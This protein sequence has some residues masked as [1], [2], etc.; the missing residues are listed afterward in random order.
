MTIEFYRERAGGASWGAHRARNPFSLPTPT[1]PT[2]LLTIGVLR[3]DWQQMGRQYG[4]RAASD[5]AQ[6]WDLDWEERVLN[7]TGV[8]AQSR[9]PSDRQAYRQQ[10]LQ[11]SWREVDALS[12]ELAQFMRGVAEGAAGALAASA[13]AEVVPDHLKIL[14]LNESD[15]ALHP[16]W[17]FAADRPGDGVRDLPGADSYV[18]DHDNQGDGCNGVWISGEGTANGHALAQRAVQ[19]GTGRSVTT[20]S[21]VAVPDDPR[22][23]VFWG[24]GRAGCLGGLGALLNDAGVC[25]LTSG[26]Q[27]GDV[28]ETLAPGVKDFLLAAYGVIFSGS[29]REAAERITVGTP[30]YRART[31]RRTVLR[32]RGANVMFGDPENACVVESNARHFCI[33]DAADAG[34][35][36]HVAVMANHFVADSSVDEHGRP[37]AARP[38]R[39]FEPGR[40]GSRGRFWTGSWWLQRNYG[41]ASVKSVKQ[42]AGSHTCCDEDGTERP[43]DQA[44][45]RQTHHPETWCAHRAGED[46]RNE[47]LGVDG[48]NMTTVFDLTSREVWFVPGWPCHYAEWGMEWNYLNLADYTRAD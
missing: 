45:G 35:G 22:A 5:I 32:F 10:Y 38:M 17:D 12:P 2:R 16:A 47:P 11:R 42:F 9:T 25:A 46:D 26:S 44:T 3:G 40:A 18:D 13:F 39:E 21:Y 41:S 29:A 7:C 34:D 33:R 24:F 6:H 36:R 30:E 1:L 37:D 14:F 20:V 27:G 28:D 43:P 23:H 48:N 15:A 8:W 31:G 19:A 4:E